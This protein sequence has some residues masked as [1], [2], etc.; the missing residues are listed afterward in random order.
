MRRMMVV[1]AGTIGLLL[2]ADRASGQSSSY[3]APSATTQQDLPW[4]TSGRGTIGAL[5]SLEA[6]PEARYLPGIQ[7]AQYLSLK[8]NPE[9]TGQRVVA[10]PDGSWFAT[11]S[12]E[13]SG[14]VDDSG[15][16]RAEELMK[17]LLRDEET[18]NRKRAEAGLPSLH[19]TGW[20]MEPQ[21]DSSTNSLQWGLRIRSDDG[22][23]ILNRTVRI[24]GREGYVSG[25]LVTTQGMT[26]PAIMA[27]DAVN[28]TVRFERGSKYI[29]FREGD[30]IAQYGM[31]ALV[32]G[33]VGAVAIKTGAAQGIF[34]ALFT[35]IEGI[36][37]IVAAMLT[38]MY[39]GISTMRRRLRRNAERSS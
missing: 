26:T 35:G 24:L 33:G 34:A 13:P 27:F 37:A 36:S 25:T 32:T 2:A 22:Q 10:P 9:Q 11:Y 39:G 30:R 29:E 28:R 23:D 16:L 8:G 3:V 20:E 15:D 14:H 7:S 18:S 19:I 17:A 4:Q 1:S 38:A 5:A 31:S 6:S 21:Y 12:Y